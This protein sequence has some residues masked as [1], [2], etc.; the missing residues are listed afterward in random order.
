[1]ARVVDSERPFLV[2][3][4]GDGLVAHGSGLGTLAQS[5]SK[6]DYSSPRSDPSE[7]ALVVELAT[8]FDLVQVAMGQNKATDWRKHLKGFRMMLFSSKH[9]RSYVDVRK[10][11][12]YLTV[13]PTRA[14]EIVN[15]DKKRGVTNTYHLMFLFDRLLSES[16]GGKNETENSFS[17]RKVSIPGA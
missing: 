17:K 11:L 12:D 4:T 3:G 5:I 15:K 16:D 1:M 2:P 9:Q 14:K 13:N 8:K 10:V 7:E 6:L